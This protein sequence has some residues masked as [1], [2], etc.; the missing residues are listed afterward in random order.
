MIE[1]KT[2]L[3]VDDQESIIKSLKRLLLSEAYDI[4]SAHDGVA[5]LEIIKQ[6]HDEIFLIISDQRM[7][8]M[9][10]TMFLERTVALLPDAIRFL[11]SGYSDR[12]DVVKAL[13][14]GVA[15]RYLTKPWSNEELI[16][17]IHQAYES[18]EK[19][20]Q[21]VDSYAR[22]S[23]SEL[24]KSNIMDR[25]LQQFSDNRNDRA[26][27]KIA[28]HHGFITQKQLDSAFTAM[29]SARQE[30]RKVSL[31]NI[32][33]E[34]GLISSEDM[35]KVLAATRRK[36]GKTFAGVAM[37]EFGVSR[38]DIDRCLAIQAQ[39]FKETTTCRLLGDILVTEK[40]LTEEQKESIIIDQIYSERDL[41]LAG[42]DSDE[43]SGGSTSE[44]GDMA[45]P[46][47]DYPNQEEQA[48]DI[49]AA[50]DEI[51]LNRRKKSFFRQR[52]LDKVFCK[53]AINRNFATEQEILKAL[54]EQLIHFTKTFE[55]ISVR[56][57]LVDRSIISK[58][59]AEAIATAMAQPQRPQAKSL[60]ETNHGY[61][62]PAEMAEQEFKEAPQGASFLQQQA[63]EVP[64]NSSGQKKILQTGKNSAFE[65]TITS[66]DTEAAIRVVGD[67]PEEI[68]AAQLKELLSRNQIIYGLADDLS[69][70]L[71]LR[72]AATRKEDFIIAKGRKAKPGRDALVKYYFENE[73]DRFGK[74]LASGKFDYR[75]R[76]E[77]LNVTQGTLLAEKIPI[78]PAV[79]G[80]TV[81]GTEI[82]APAPMDLNLNCGQGVE[83]SKDGL[84]VIATANGRPDRSLGGKIT[85][86]S[87]KIVKG[88]VDFRTGNIRFNGDIV[89]QGIILAGFSVTGNNLTVNDIEDAEVNIANTLIVKNSINVS[90]IRAGGHITAQIINKSTVFA[91]GDVTV[92]K[93]IIDCTI[94]TSGKV[95]VPRGRILASKIYA[96][97]GVEAMS[98]G[99]DISAP[100]HLFPGADEHAREVLRVYSEK[101]DAQREHLKKLEAAEKQYERQSLKQLNDLSELSRLQERLSIEKKK[102]LEDKK[103]V[104]N[105]IVQRQID[106]FLADLYKRSLQMDETINKLFDEN[107]ITQTK[108]REV[109]A[110]IRS[111]RIEMEQMLNE[112]N[113]FEKWYETQKADLLKSGVGV[114]VQGVISAGTR[115]TGTEC[116]MSV[117]SP[118]RNSRVQQVI[119]SENPDNEFNELK[120]EPLSST[121]AP[122]IYRP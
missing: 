35:G 62:T 84:R 58:F 5:A 44:R 60:T 40:I 77:I 112:K 11:L 102:S 108:S 71:F 39:E 19:I 23:V 96:T 85:I 6:H 91:H 70:E 68:T 115:I 79:N 88:N 103:S 75:D 28:V 26:L 2:I 93:E 12:D 86:M 92:Q 89:V 47:K 16:M 105:K 94:I 50:R 55:I 106:E 36:I 57:I 53:S 116:A 49:E 111:I 99:S 24:S 59:Q 34:K 100:C 46:A 69:I 97:R 76:G 10:G 37:N 95:M 65:L 54:E 107:D 72:H 38:A 9:T 61:E 21:S 42:I 18:P 109:K 119:N 17:M 78:I 48:A 45:D 104:T 74:E 98:I 29:Q 33:F 82:T 80:I 20:K 3:I 27:G 87:E 51:R 67:M 81:F 66:D 7:P 114:R 83:L 121:G 90:T 22:N 120:I 113:G 52:A 30:G 110:K 13:N 1:K 56:D 122:H 118:I 8:H 117:K 4:L 63:K 73:N 25:E 14:S 43:S 41:S 32:L 101:I 15:H 31:E 64:L